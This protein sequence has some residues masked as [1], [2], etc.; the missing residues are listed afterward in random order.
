MELLSNLLMMRILNFTN[1]IFILYYNRVVYLLIQNI[2][3]EKF[4]NFFFIFMIVVIFI[5]FL[6]NKNRDVSLVEA[7][8]DVD[9]YLV[10]CFYIMFYTF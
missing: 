10:D 3:M 8:L 2:K 5:Y 9:K 1:L 4:A 6:K 7:S